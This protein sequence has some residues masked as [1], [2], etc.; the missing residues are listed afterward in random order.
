MKASHELSP[1]PIPPIPSTATDSTPKPSDENSQQPLLHVIDGVFD[2]SPTIER[3][4]RQAAKFVTAEEEAEGRRQEISAL[5][6]RNNS[7]S[8][9]SESV[10]SPMRSGEVDGDGPDSREGREGSE[11]MDEEGATN[12]SSSSPVRLVEGS[13]SSLHITTDLPDMMKGSLTGANSP[14][15]SNSPVRNSVLSSVNPDLI[16]S[17]NRMFSPQVKDYRSLSV[18]SLSPFEPSSSPLKPQHPQ[19]GPHTPRIQSINTG[20]SL[21]MRISALNLPGDENVNPGN[22]SPFRRGPGENNSPFRGSCSPQRDGSQTGAGLTSP[23]GGKSPLKSV[24]GRQMG[25]FSVGGEK[26]PTPAASLAPSAVALATGGP[27]EFKGS[28]SKILQ[29]MQAQKEAME[30]QEKSLLS[31]GGVEVVDRGENNWGGSVAGSRSLEGRGTADA[32]PPARP[33]K[34]SPMKS[35]LMGMSFLDE[36]RAGAMKRPAGV[37]FLDQIKARSQAMEAAAGE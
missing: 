18:P 25:F 9:I 19:Q 6:N 7:V 37:S 13:Q 15:R 5:K 23:F 17:L 11:G 34:M 35:G 36:L 26:S 20:D 32:L 4:G 10:H 3:N 30:L 21:K 24:A 22:N 29:R 1:T 28:R 14:L 12:D 33:S 8:V 2:P 16:S 31:A 27:K